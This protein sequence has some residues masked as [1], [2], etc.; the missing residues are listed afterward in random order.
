MVL[1]RVVVLSSPPGPVERMVRMGV[2]RHLR[3]TRGGMVI[4]STLREIALRA[5][6]GLGF[7]APLA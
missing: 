4:L 6:V 2:F 5:S 1:P 7:K 3:L